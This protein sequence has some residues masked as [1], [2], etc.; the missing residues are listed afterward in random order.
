MRKGSIVRNESL[1]ISKIYSEDN[2]KQK[3]DEVVELDKNSKQKI[4]DKFFQSLADYIK[5]NNTSILDLIQDKVF[6]KV[7]NAREYQLIKYKHLYKILTGFGLTITGDTKQGIEYLIPPFLEQ[8][9][10]IHSLVSTLA[11]FGCYELFPK[12]NKHINYRS[13]VFYLFFP[14]EME[15][16]T[17]RIL[18]RII[19]Q[20]EK[21]GQESKDSL[22]TI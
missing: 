19:H 9:L 2:Q 20:M 4:G 13:K 11:K 5:E 10:E 15:G 12:S 7:L 22:I 8:T 18:N 16:P 1:C 21:D 17:V 6:D 14:L 3:K